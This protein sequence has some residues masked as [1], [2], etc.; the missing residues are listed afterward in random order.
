M[1]F[2]NLRLV[3]HILK[4]SSKS[5]TSHI[6]YNST[7]FALSSGKS[8]LNPISFNISQFYCSIYD[9]AG[10]GKSGVAVIRVS[11]CETSRVLA[12]MVDFKVSPI[13]RM[14]YLKTIRDPET[15]EPL[16]RGLLLWFPGNYISCQNYQ[17]TSYI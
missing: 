10:L 7:I 11:G 12:D 9:V 8:F 15:K 1:K 2:L 14:A 13:P 3:R 5:W 16:D 6:R 4:K 17:I